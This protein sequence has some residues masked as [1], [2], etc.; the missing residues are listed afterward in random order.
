MDTVLTL[1]FLIAFDFVGGPVGLLVPGNAGVPMS[2]FGGQSRLCCCLPRFGFG[3]SFA[4]TD[5]D[6]VGAGRFAGVGWR[7][8]LILI[9]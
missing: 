4:V 9:S 7:R 1:D 3:I 5:A 2:A 6:E 8:G